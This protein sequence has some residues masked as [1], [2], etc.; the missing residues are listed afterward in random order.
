MT[1]TDIAWVTVSS[2]AI[3]RNRRGVLK[4]TSMAKA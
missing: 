1:Q 4:S 3:R 2:P